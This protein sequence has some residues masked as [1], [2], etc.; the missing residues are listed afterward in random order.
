MAHSGLIYPAAA[1]VA[2][3]AVH[4]SVL[5]SPRFHTQNYSHLLPDPRMYTAVLCQSAKVSWA[6]V[7]IEY[8][9]KFFS[10]ASNFCFAVR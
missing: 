5:P 1:V 8:W 9:E 3:A 4:N 2:A 10:L 6:G 7:K